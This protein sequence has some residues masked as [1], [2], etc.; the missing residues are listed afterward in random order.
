MTDVSVIIVNYNTFHLTQACLESIYTHTRGVHIEVIVVDNNSTERNPDE[1]KKIFPQIKL[2]KNAENSGF[3]KGNNVGIAASMGEYILLLNSD[4][5]LLNDAIAIVHKFLQNHKGVAV[6][7]AQLQY[8]NGQVQ[9]NCQRFPSIS[10]TLFELFRLQK[11]MPN[12][13]ERVLL[14]SFFKHDVIVYP[15]WVWGTFFMFPKVLLNTF[16]DKKLAETFFMYGE[17]MEWCMEFKNRGYSIGFVP[18][19][20]VLHHLG[21]SGATANL[22][23]QQN[24]ITFLQQYYSPFHQWVLRMLNSLLRITIRSR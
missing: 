7:A 17:D 10:A 21:K 20:K 15:D 16:P 11:L 19:A 18:E 2:I 8:P 9:H 1:L 4:T 23:I 13:S 3:A 12:F 6:A 22:W 5:A 24:N 14:G